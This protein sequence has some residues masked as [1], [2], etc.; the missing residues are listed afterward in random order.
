MVATWKEN[1]DSIETDPLKA[2]KEF[3]GNPYIDA[4]SRPNLLYKPKQRY[5]NNCIIEL[6]RVFK[7][8]EKELLMGSNSPHYSLVEGRFPIAYGDEILNCLE[9]VIR[10][11]SYDDAQFLHN[12]FEEQE[13]EEVY[14]DMVDY[15]AI[16]HLIGQ[17]LA[18]SPA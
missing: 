5:S 12:A 14:L 18:K 6:Q 3:C 17:C 8:Y 13:L 2:Y 4:I 11:M 1:S 15:I 10:A 7:Q 9:D 16:R